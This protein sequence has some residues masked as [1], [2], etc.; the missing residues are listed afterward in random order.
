MTIEEIE[1]RIKQIEDEINILGTSEQGKKILINASYGFISS[2]YSSLANSNLGSA[3]TSYGRFNIKAMTKKVIEEIG[4]DVYCSL[5]DTDS[6]HLALGSTIPKEVTDP[7]ERTKLIYNYTTENI[8]PIIVNYSKEISSMFNGNGL[9]EMDFEAIARKTLVTGKKRY[10]CELYY[11]DKFLD[12]MKKKVIGIE[13]KRSS[14]PD[15]VKKALDRLL[16]LIFEGDNVLVSSFIKKYRKL[17]PYVDINK[18]AIPTS[19]SNM[20]KYYND[21]KGKNRREQFIPK[22]AIA[23]AKAVHLHNILIDE[24][25]ELIGFEHILTGNKLKMVPLLHHIDANFG[26]TVLAFKEWTFLRETGIRT[27]K[28]YEKGTKIEDMIDYTE[29]FNKTFLKPATS[30]LDSIGWVVDTD[31]LRRKGL[32]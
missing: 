5:Q 15:N 1:A 20:E 18:I 31:E 23:S 7:F 3:I 25:E 28:I 13:I 22:G 11:D 29:L 27:Q 6:F 4:G 10:A 9:L 2:S 12:K 8:S 26:N 17:H 32:F 19:V 16:D 21:K 24:N 14:T 30:L